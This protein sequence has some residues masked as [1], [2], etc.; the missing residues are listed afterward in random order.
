MFANKIL[1]YFRMELPV[2]GDNF[3]RSW[4][5]HL[6]H[7]INCLLLL[8]PCIPSSLDKGLVFHWTLLNSVNFTQNCEILFFIKWKFSEGRGLLVCLGN[9]NVFVLIKTR[10]TR[11]SFLNRI[12]TG[13]QVGVTHVCYCVL[14]FRMQVIYSFLKHKIFKLLV[15]HILN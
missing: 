14:N 2:S 5:R 11:A 8:M 1:M 12:V 10:V 7:T 9:P 13:L 4:S 3:S 15:F 6:Y